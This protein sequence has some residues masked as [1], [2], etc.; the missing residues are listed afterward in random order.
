MCTPAA[1]AVAG[2]TAAGV[3]GVAAYNNR[4]TIKKVS[5]S[6]EGKALLDAMSGRPPL[7]LITTNM[8]QY[9]MGTMGEVVHDMVTYTDEKH[10]EK[11]EKQRNDICKKGTGSSRLINVRAAGGPFCNNPFV[12]DLANFVCLGEDESGNNTE[13]LPIDGFEKSHCWNQC[14]EMKRIPNFTRKA[15]ADLYEIHG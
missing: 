2:V 14:I 6:K 5:N 10:K 15:I 12:C 11:I 1:P 8:K 9:L 4:E 7:E 3:A 13:Y